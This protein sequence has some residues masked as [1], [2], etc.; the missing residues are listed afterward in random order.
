LT[1]WVAGG[2]GFEDALRRTRRAEQ[3]ESTLLAGR[4]LVLSA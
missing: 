3:E 4:E 1:A 2:N